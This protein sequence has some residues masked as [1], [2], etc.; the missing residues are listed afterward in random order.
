V[1]AADERARGELIGGRSP[2]IDD[3]RRDD[4]RA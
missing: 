1:D 2:E 3:E 4:Q